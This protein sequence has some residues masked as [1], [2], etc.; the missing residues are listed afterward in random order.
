MHNLPRHRNYLLP[1]WRISFL[2]TCTNHNVF[3]F[4]TFAWQ[5]HKIYIQFGT[6]RCDIFV[7]IFV[8]PQFYYTLFWNFEW[9]FLSTVNF[10]PSGLLT[11]TLSFFFFILIS[12]RSVYFFFAREIYDFILLRNE[13]SF[14]Y[15]SCWCNFHFPIFLFFQFQHLNKYLKWRLLYVLRCWNT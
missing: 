2:L 5:Q 8:T 6:P 11:A 3:S 14:Y 15:R 13:E 4:S 7:F 10:T 9:C 12:L 1:S